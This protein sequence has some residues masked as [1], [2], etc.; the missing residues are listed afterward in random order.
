MAGS[1]FQA[2]TGPSTL[3][4]TL[5]GLSNGA[6]QYSTS[7]SSTSTATHFLDA[8]VT[9]SCFVATA[10]TSDQAVYFFVYGTVDGGTTFTD[11]VTGTDGVLTTGRR[12]ARSLGVLSMTSPNVV[13]RGG[14][15]SVAQ[16]F[17][18]VLPQQWGVIAVN[19]TGT[20]LSNANNNANEVK[21]QHVWEQYT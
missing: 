19:S 1:I 14:P 5:N 11:N 8:L 4:F 9:A 2:F 12:N 10:P 7:V 17:G 15:W 21:Y 16:A 18:G 6:T 20:Y 13:T 3:T